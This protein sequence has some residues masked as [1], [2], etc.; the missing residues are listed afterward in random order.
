[1]SDNDKTQ[2]EITRKV[3]RLG[4]IT[5]IH[6]AAINVVTKAAMEAEK[7]VME[8]TDELEQCKI[9]LQMSQDRIRD[10]ENELES[11]NWDRPIH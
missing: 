6:T 8:L 11:T 5:T 1:L 7:R 9:E 2:L 3:R 10:L 4:A